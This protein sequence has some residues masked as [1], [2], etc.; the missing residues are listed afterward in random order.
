MRKAFWK[1][2]NHTADI[3]IEV[4][5]DSYVNLVLES[6]K[7]FSEITT[8]VEEIGNAEKYHV[9]VEAEELDLLLVEFLNELLFLL[10]TED[11]V[12]RCFES[13]KHFVDRN[14]IIFA[15][16]AIGGK[17]I[18]EIH[19]SRSEIKAVTYHELEVRMIKSDSWYAK[20]LFDV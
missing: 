4:W 16:K 12:A 5:A 7:A 1:E 17:W 2:Y 11:F 6:G 13:P 18:Q 9:I 3:G 15:V 8:N 19:E 20:I 10:E 14:K